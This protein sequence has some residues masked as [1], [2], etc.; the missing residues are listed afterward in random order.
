M[1]REEVDELLAPPTAGAVCR[2]SE[3]I[4]KVLFSHR[5]E[6]LRTFLKMKLPDHLNA[7]VFGNQL[8]P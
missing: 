2:T 7:P 6:A 5:S 8:S 4:R 3:D 1:C